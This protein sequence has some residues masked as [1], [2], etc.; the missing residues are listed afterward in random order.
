M[1]SPKYDHLNV[2]RPSH[3][4]FSFPTDVGC[5]PS[6]LAA[7]L[8]ISFILHVCG[9]PFSFTFS[10]PF[11]GNVLF[12][13]ESQPERRQVQAPVEQEPAQKDWCEPGLG[14]KWDYPERQLQPAKTLELVDLQGPLK[15]LDKTAKSEPII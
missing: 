8:P 14:A 13:G 9:S 6:S 11:F 15:S 1:N 4:A 10:F 12:L 2:S 3:W 7:A 5:L